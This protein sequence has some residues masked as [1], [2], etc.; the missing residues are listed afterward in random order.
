MLWAELAAFVPPRPAVARI[1]TGPNRKQLGLAVTHVRVAEETDHAPQVPR[2][3]LLLL[4]LGGMG[5]CLTSGGRRNTFHSLSFEDRRLA[6]RRGREA[7]AILS[8]AHELV[9]R[10]AFT[11]TTTRGRASSGG[12]H[13]GRRTIPASPPPPQALPSPHHPQPTHPGPRQAASQQHTLSL[14]LSPLWPLSELAPGPLLL[15]LYPLPQAC[16]TASCP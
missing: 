16:M 10:S 2:L 7:C 14:S 1:A 12:G 6:L 8:D 3:V 15:S 5:S 11:R 13:R 4:N 9:R